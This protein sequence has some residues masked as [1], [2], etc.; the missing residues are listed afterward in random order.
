MEDF[1]DGGWIPSDRPL[2]PRRPGRR[3]LLIGALALAFMLTLGVGAVLGS[4]IG[5]AL[6]AGFGSASANSAQAQVYGPQAYGPGAQG[7]HGQ[8][9]ALT[10][11]SVSGSTIVAK[12]ADGSTVTVH[13]SASTQ[14][15]RNG[16]SAAAS[17]VTAGSQ[18][19]VDGTRNSDGSINATSIDI[20]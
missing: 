14:Y 16:Q 5:G 10:V 8:C 15:T 6:A 9:G 17:A 12:A 20:G 7:A 13:T 18:I 3:W 11:S 2:A 4:S 19:H 1:G